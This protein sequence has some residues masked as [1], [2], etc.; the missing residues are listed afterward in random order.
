MSDPVLIERE[1]LLAMAEKMAEVSART[2]LEGLGLKPREIKTWISQNKAYKL[3][4]RKRIETAVR[5]GHIRK[6]KKDI[7][8]PKSRVMYRLSDVTK[9]IANPLV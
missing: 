7:D 4:G 1:T 8:N 9:L 6:H 2:M 3:A 5:Q